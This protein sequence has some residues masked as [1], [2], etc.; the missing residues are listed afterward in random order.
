[1]NEGFK[2]FICDD[3]ENAVEELHRRAVKNLSG[4][5]SYEIKHFYD[6]ESLLKHC[7]KEFPDA[8][9][10]DIDM[11]NINGFEVSCELQR[12]N[13]RIFIVF[14][15][16]YE[17]KVYQSW[18]Y[19]PF[20]FV[21]KTHLDDLNV[22]LPKLLLKLE[23]ERARNTS[24]VNFFVGNR[25]IALDVNEIMYIEAFDHEINIVF[26]DGKTDTYRSRLSD[27]ENQLSTYDII[28]VQK[29]IL[30]NLRFVSKVT[31]RE[32]TLT[33]STSF[34]LGRHLVSDVR[35]RFYNYMRSV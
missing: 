22:V 34:S 12:I 2:L 29:G 21:R 10:L 1:M 4:T 33:D 30:V 7:G 11:P 26:K 13:E 35:N 31:S 19:S 32:I 3:N 28:R 23:K 20:W 15:T 16:S 9:L 24:V 14:V 17:D 25:V 5:I 6:G 18:S 8:V 27:A